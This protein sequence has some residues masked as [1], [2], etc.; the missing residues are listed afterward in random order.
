M[1]L[2]DR[3]KKFIVLSG[4]VAKKMYGNNA[5]YL[6]IVEETGE[7]LLFN[8]GG[9][10]IE[11]MIESE[12]KYATEDA[13]EAGIKAKMAKSEGANVEELEKIAAEKKEAAAIKRRETYAAKKAASQANTKAMKDKNI[14]SDAAT[15]T[16]QG[17]PV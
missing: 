7:P 10:C 3:R 2:L 16:M 8:C 1:R 13:I 14:A 11:D 17:G 9:K 15:G 12:V 6:Q 4:K 5:R